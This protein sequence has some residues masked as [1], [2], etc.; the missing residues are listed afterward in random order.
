[1]IGTWQDSLGEDTSFPTNVIRLARALSP[2]AIVKDE[3][4][5]EREVEQVVYYQP[6]VGTGVGDKLRGGN[7]HLSRVL[8][9]Q[10]VTLNRHLRSRCLSACSGRLR[11]SR[12]QL[13]PRSWR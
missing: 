3:N 13:R 9:D 10:K 4:G 12:P 8:K 2:Y 6:G 5:E 7:Q 1:M 11:L